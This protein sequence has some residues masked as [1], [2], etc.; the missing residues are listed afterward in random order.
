MLRVRLTAD[1]NRQMAA[2]N[3]TQ[4]MVSI[5]LRPSDANDVW[6]GGRRHRPCMPR[7]DVGDRAPV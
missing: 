7:C 4:L 3:A 6:Y 2:A 5:G 1:M